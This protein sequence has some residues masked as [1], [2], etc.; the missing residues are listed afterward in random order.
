MGSTDLKP[1]FSS[2]D[3][4]NYPSNGSSTETDVE[5]SIG[6]GTLVKGHEL[7]AFV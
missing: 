2:A 6:R 4:E 3:K 1:F 7:V 5:Q